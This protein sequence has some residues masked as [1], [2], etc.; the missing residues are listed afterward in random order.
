[1]RESLALHLPNMGYERVELERLKNA[2][3][4]RIDELWQGAP[5]ARVV[6][7]QMDSRAFDFS[8]F[9]KG[10]W[11]FV[12]NDPNTIHDWALSHESVLTAV[13]QG[14]IVQIFSTM[15]C[16]VGGLHRLMWENG[17]DIWPGYMEGI[18]DIVCARRTL[19]AILIVLEKDSSQWAY[20]FTVPHKWRAEAIA[21]AQQISKKY[22]IGIQA[23]SY[24]Y[25]QNAYR[26]AKDKLVRTAKELAE[27]EGKQMK[28]GNFEEA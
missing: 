14:A 18:E 26:A 24:L 9:K 5:M 20:L 2:Q 16:N 10:D 25:D 12:V 28:L 19:D 8:R 4:L 17:R 3:E 22:E 13:N 1:L 27:L 7:C 6:T 15:G 21:E 23:F 11:L